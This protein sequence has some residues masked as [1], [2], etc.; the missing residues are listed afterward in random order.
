MSEIFK[1]S[2]N[3]MWFFDTEYA[4]CL[5]TARRVYGLP[6]DLSDADALEA[7]YAANGATEDNPRP[8]LKLFLYQVVSISTLLRTR[9]ANGQI[10][11][12]FFTLPATDITE[13]EMLNR[14]LNA[15]GTAHPQLVGF[16]SNL[17]DMT[18]LFQ[19]ALINKC[20]IPEY[21]R[22]PDKPWEGA[23]YFSK[24]SDYVVDLMSV[25]G[26][27]ANKANPKLDE[28]AKACRIP[29]KLGVDG[30]EV[31]AMWLAGRHQEIIDY[32]ETDTATTYLLWLEL[33]RMAQHV[34]NAA[35]E[36]ERLLF[37]RLLADRVTTG[38]A[39]FQA[40]LDA[41]D[42]TPPAGEDSAL[43]A[44]LFDGDPDE[45]QVVT[46]WTGTRA[47]VRTADIP[48]GTISYE[49]A[50]GK[51]SCYGNQIDDDHPS[52]MLGEINAEKIA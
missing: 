7:T 3:N 25:I 36:S 37:Y 26:G 22:R 31:A 6:D 29:G 11:L 23:D 16:A 48:T 33:A 12:R 49:Y 20:T 9:E 41:W 8:M 30:N 10:S 21:C 46:D 18:V 44:A 34:S 13:Q 1:H 28:I 35:Y 52:V 15:V 45:L 32:N 24:S 27:Y 38:A 39:H 19:R 51:M 17:F 40:F 47:K 5:E 43:L 42:F 14:F 4:P 2:M 50:D